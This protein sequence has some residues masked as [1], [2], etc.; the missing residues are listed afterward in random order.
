MPTGYEKIYQALLPKLAEVDIIEQ[1]KRLG[2]A[3]EGQASAKVDFLGRTYLY[4]TEGVDVID[5]GEPAPINNRSLLIHYIL[6]EGG[7]E[8][9]FSFVPI[10]RMTGTIE[11]QGES[12]EAFMGDYL[13]KETEGKH[14]VFAAAAE[15]MRGEYIGKHLGGHCWQFM[16][17]PK[18]PM[19][20]IF[21]EADEEFPADIQVL[22]DETAPYYMDFEC[23]GF[24]SEGALRELLFQ[25]QKQLGREETAYLLP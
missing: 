14:D 7:I 6:A 25:V 2:L 12:D 22:F 21:F 23:S 9:R 10:N 8:P 18:M 16:V 24:L 20:M 15:A 4:S 19:R 1:A 3:P 11:G 5:G 17:L 13:I